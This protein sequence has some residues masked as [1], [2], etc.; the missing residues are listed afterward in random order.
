MAHKNRLPHSETPS[1]H[2]QRLVNH[3][4]K[5]QDELAVRNTE[6][7][8]LRHVKDAKIKKTQTVANSHDAHAQKL[9][10]QASALLAEVAQQTEEARPARVVIKQ[11]QAEIDGLDEELLANRQAA[12]G[13]KFYDDDDEYL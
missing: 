7:K 5:R 6:L 3:P 10:R 1:P 2:S 8:A 9:M 13:C 4:T 11:E 12:S